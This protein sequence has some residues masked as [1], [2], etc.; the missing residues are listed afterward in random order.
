MKIILAWIRESC[1]VKTMKHTTNIKVNFSYQTHLNEET[2]ELNIALFKEDD[3]Q[4][5][6]LTYWEAFVLLEKLKLEF[7]EK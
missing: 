5:I 7:C 2:K 3:E 4:E 6:N 1:M